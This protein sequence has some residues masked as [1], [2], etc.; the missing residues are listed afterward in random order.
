MRHQPDETPAGAPTPVRDEGF[1]LLEVVVSLGMLAVV[2]SAA[3]SFF[4]T[5]I[6]DS[7][8]LQRR[9]TAVALTS[10]AVEGA[11]GVTATT[12]NRTDAGVTTT[13]TGLVRGRAAADVAAQWAASSAPG[14]SETYPASDPAATDSARA[15][16]PLTTTA[17]VSRQTYSTSVLIGT[18]Y[19][20]RSDTSAPC[21]TAP[22]ATR[23][24]TPPSGYVEMVRVIA[25]TTWV[26]G[27]RAS[28]S[29]TNPCAYTTT[30][31]VDPSTDPTWS[32]SVGDAV[33]DVATVRRG[34]TAVLNVLSNDTVVAASSW[35]VSVT[36]QPSAG[37]ATARADGTI[38][39]EVPASAGTGALELQYVVRNAAGG[40]TSSATVR[41]TVT[42]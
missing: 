4:L 14:R 33:D 24:T 3:L 35:P 38:E 42:S 11:R 26:P 40:T 17:R 28:C 5:G 20:L 21:D 29:T 36:V 19:R 25:T 15:L 22:S 7:A 31:L 13:Y 16:V 6:S 37:T 32:T 18:C 39:L 8:Q 34:T 9:Q 27:V 1:S 10:A 12:V 2:S 30:V 41:V 23:A